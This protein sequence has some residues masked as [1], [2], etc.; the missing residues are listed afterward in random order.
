MRMTPL[1][2]EK[3]IAELAAILGDSMA[4]IYQEYLQ[5]APTHIAA[6]SQALAADDI[7]TL[8]HA[9]HTLKGSSG[10]LGLMAVYDASRTL[11]LNA[12][13][14]NIANGRAELHQLEAIYAN[15]RQHLLQRFNLQ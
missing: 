15:T 8:I 2:D 4:D 10:N 7:N 3:V 1:L 5:D 14:G 11:E 12:K 13:A 9:A 6:I